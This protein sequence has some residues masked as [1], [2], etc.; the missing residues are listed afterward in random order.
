MSYRAFDRRAVLLE[1]LELETKHMS[2]KLDLV[3]SLF[4]SYQHALR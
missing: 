1:F 2:A 3:L 4:A